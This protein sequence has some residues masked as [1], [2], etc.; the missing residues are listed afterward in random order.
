MLDEETDIYT[1]QSLTLLSTR[2]L[3][4]AHVLRHVGL[5]SVCCAV[6]QACVSCKDDVGKHDLAGGV[7]RCV[8]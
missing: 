4:H 2:R 3:T 7:R 8:I 1:G 6:T 5:L